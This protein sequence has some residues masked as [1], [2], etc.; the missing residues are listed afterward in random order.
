MTM[1]EFVGSLGSKSC[2]SQAKNT[3]TLTVP[4]NNVAVS[5]T[6]PN[7]LTLKFAKIW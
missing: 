2:E 6:F 3:S 4:V 7:K 1:T 5:N